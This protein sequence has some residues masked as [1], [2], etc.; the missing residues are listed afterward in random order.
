MRLEQPNK[1]GICCCAQQHDQSELWQFFWAL[2]VAHGVSSRQLHLFC[3]RK[4]VLDAGN[5]TALV[6][7]SSQPAA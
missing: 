4:R 3:L 2:K 7:C 5:R 1:E 6:C